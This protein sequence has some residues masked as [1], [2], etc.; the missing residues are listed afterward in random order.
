MGLVGQG[1]L[2]RHPVSR[3]PGCLYY[4]GPSPN[5]AAKI[6]LRAIDPDR[7]QIVNEARGHEVMEEIEDSKAFYEVYDGAVYMYQ[8][9]E[10]RTRL[11]PLFGEGGR[12][13][14][15]CVY[16]YNNISIGNAPLPFSAGPDVPVQQAGPVRQGGHRAPRGPQVL[17][18]ALR[19]LRRGRQ[20]RPPSI[21]AGGFSGQLCN[22]LSHVLVLSS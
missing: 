3:D 15:A 10:E 20:G 1:F 13:S 19:L 7:F 6:S 17:H 18:Q 5:P 12:Q 8:V 22:D 9:G 21:C 4:T 11:S 2:S 14:P 16:T